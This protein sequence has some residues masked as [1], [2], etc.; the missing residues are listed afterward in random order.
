MRWYALHDD[1]WVRIERQLP[2]WACR[3]VTP[4][5][6]RGCG[7]SL[8]C[9]SSLTR[10]FGLVRFVKGNAYVV[11]LRAKSRV[12][13]H[14]LQHFAAGWGMECAM[15]DSTF[16]GAHQHTAGAHKQGRA[17]R[18]LGAARWLEYQ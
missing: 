17:S 4:P 18:R 3:R 14:L 12:W 13:E 7:L 6:S 15:L 2:C 8:P 11:Q 16:V 9:G 1:V 5:V 10:N